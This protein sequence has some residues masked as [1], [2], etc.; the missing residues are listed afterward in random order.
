MWSGAVAWSRDALERA[1][2]A[3]DLLRNA[4]DV[5]RVAHPSTKAFLAEYRPSDDEA[6]QTRA[7]SRAFIARAEAGNAPDS[8]E[9][10]RKRIEARQRG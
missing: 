2:A 4:K 8:T 10:V 5:P 3:V 9:Y 1:K 7:A 6:A